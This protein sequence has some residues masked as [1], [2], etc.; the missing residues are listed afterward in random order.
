MTAELNVWEGQWEAFWKDG[1]RGV[2]P[3]FVRRGV[4]G[5][6]MEYLIE[7]MKQRETNPSSFL[8]YPP[9][10][11]RFDD[12]G[13]NHE[14]GEATIGIRRHFPNSIPPLDN[15]SIPAGFVSEDIIESEGDVNPIGVV[16][17]KPFMQF[18]PTNPDYDGAENSEEKGC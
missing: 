8:G 12:I 18:D 9:G 15:N 16:R 10:C 13:Y 5:Y 7:R 1:N 11:L 3:D 14:T 17:S 2:N 4:T 6:T